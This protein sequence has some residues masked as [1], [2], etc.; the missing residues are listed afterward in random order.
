MIRP[1]QFFCLCVAV[2][3]I[4][5]ESPLSGEDAIKLWPEQPPGKALDVGPE[6]DFTKPE[7]NLIAGERI[8][9][10]GNVSTPEVHVFLPPKA[11]RS[12]AAVVICPGG[13]FNIL[14]WDLEG[15]EVAEWLNTQGVA[16][17]V[18]KY[19]VPTSKQDPRWK[20]PVQDAQR[21]ISLT[22]HHAKDW[23]LK[24][25]Q[26][27]ILGFSAGGHTAA[28]TAIMTERQYEPIDEIDQSSHSP[29]SA[30]L[31]YP[32]WLANEQGTALLDDLHVTKE[33]PPMF[34]VHAYNDPISA[35]SS[36]LLFVELKKAEVPAEIH[37]FESGGHGYGLRNIDDQ[38]VTR[39]PNLCN[40]WMARIGWTSGKK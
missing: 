32:A 4:I 40:E 18:L 7:D 6:K 34:L 15:T 5:T 35:L 28:R 1:L 2:C 3:L 10:L 38:P 36:A 26:I 30:I 19:R 24:T 21:A 29:N 23:G 37:V 27:G 25:D 39:W 12:G 31:I 13:G 8:I 16:G 11:N 17:I 22:R 20:A 14:A 9:K 33:T